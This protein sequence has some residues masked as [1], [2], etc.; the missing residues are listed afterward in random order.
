M[1]THYTRGAVESNNAEI[2]K[3]KSSHPM[4]AP[5]RGCAIVEQLQLQSFMATCQDVNPRSKRAPHRLPRD[6]RV[7]VGQ[8]PPS[9]PR[10]SIQKPA[11]SLG[12]GERNKWF[13]PKQIKT[14]SFFS[15]FVRSVATRPRPWVHWR[16]HRQEERHGMLYTPVAPYWHV[17]LSG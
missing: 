10:E 16:S 7:L 3:R 2:F 13:L 17:A 11:N 14:S 5:Q 9:C 6:S 8:F 12:V 4:P 15:S 1:L